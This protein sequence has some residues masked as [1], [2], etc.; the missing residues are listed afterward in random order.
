MVAKAVVHSTDES[1]SSVEDF[2]KQIDERTMTDEN[3]K[4]Y[5]RVVSEMLSS[6]KVHLT[7]LDILKEVYLQPIIKIGSTENV[8]IA[9][10]IMSQIVTLIGVHKK[11]LAMMEE[12]EKNA[13]ADELPFFGDKFVKNIQFLKM[14]SSYITKYPMYL[15]QLTSITKKEKD[16]V[17]AQNKARDEYMKEHPEVKGIQAFSFYLITP[18]QRIPRYELLIRDMLKDVGQDFSDVEGL[19][20]AYLEAKESAK[21][22]NSLKTQYEEGEKI[23]F[24]KSIIKGS[25][26]FEADKITRRFICCGPMYFL[27]NVQD[28]PTELYYYFLF[29][30]LLIQTRVKRFKLV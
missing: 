22:S 11:F 5:R 25:P 30:D 15:E 9:K 3:K 27:K 1:S 26:E 24:L 6:E 12:G 17:K 28:I 10:A 7:G 13:K 4:H 18:I 19:K 16:I 21:G 14:A 23:N 29:N 20:K 8:A 2:F